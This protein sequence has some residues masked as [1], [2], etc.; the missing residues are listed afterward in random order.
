MS[1]STTIVLTL[2]EATATRMGVCFKILEFMSSDDIEDILDS[3]GEDERPDEYGEILVKFAR[4]M[5]AQFA[6]IQ[7]VAA[8]APSMEA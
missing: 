6:A 1:S 4:G 3:M 5:A 8:D 2:P 7:E